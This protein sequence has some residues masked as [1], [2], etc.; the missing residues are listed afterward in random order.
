MKQSAK[1]NSAFVRPDVFCYTIV[2]NAWANSG[3]SNAYTRI[4][5]LYEQMEEDNVEPNIVTYTTLLTFLTKFKEREMVQRS[6][7][8]LQCMEESERSDIQP[9]Y[10]QYVPVIDGY[11]SLGDVNNAMQIFMRF[12]M[13]RSSVID[14]AAK[15]NLIFME[16]MMQEWIKAGD[17][18]RVTPLVSKMQELK[19]VKLLPEGPNSQTYK[20][21]LDAWK[22]SQ[23]PEKDDVIERIEDILAEL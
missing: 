13:A 22:R 4:W 19:D 1:T 17:L 21:L 15:P 12:A 5:R 16:T 20:S 7:W 2:I 18:N 10:W 11:L 23:R 3:D 9:D 6:D 14:P 8:L